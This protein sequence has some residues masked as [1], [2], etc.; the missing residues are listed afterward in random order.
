MFL[1]LAILDF[2]KLKTRPQK[3]SGK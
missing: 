2:E 1:F 3:A